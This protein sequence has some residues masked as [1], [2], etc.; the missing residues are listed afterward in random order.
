MY[1]NLLLELLDI[2]RETFKVS[3]IKISYSRK[4]NSL[5]LR[6]SESN[7]DTL[8]TT[9]VLSIEDNSSI[10]Y[11]YLDK[12]IKPKDSLDY[13]DYPEDIK[14]RVFIFLKNILFNYKLNPEI[15]KDYICFDNSDKIESIFISG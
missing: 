5:N 12:H 4:N 8:K 1:H 13:F 3:K 6:I 7:E 14:K 10:K 9:I 11:V 15:L 2:Y